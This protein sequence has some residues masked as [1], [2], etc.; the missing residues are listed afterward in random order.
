MGI[1]I[2]DDLAEIEVE[3][4]KLE[5]MEKELKKIRPLHDKLVLEILITRDDI[6]RKQKELGENTP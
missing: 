4:I 3:R 5:A 2:E 6:K 1:F